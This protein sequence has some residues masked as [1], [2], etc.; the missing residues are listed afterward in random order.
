MN[1]DLLNESRSLMPG[2]GRPHW[3][4]EEADRDQIDRTLDEVGQMVRAFKSAEPK[5]RTMLE[6]MSGIKGWESFGAAMKHGRVFVPFGTFLGIQFILNRK[7]GDVV[8][9]DRVTFEVSPVHDGGY[10]EWGIQASSTVRNV[11]KGHGSDR[12]V[13]YHDMGHWKDPDVWTDPRKALAPLKGFFRKA[14]MLKP[15][16]E[17][18]LRRSGELT[19]GTK[20]PVFNPYGMGMWVIRVEDYLY[21]ITG[22]KW[23][24]KKPILTIEG[25]KKIQY[26]WVGRK[27]RGA[28]SPPIFTSTVEY[29]KGPDAFDIETAYFDGNHIVASKTHHHVYIEQA[30]DPSV[31]FGWVKQKWS[32]KTGMKNENAPGP[33]AVS[34]NPPSIQDM[35]DAVREQIKAPSWTY[36]TWALPKVQLDEIKYKSPKLDSRLAKKVMALGKKAFEDGRKSIPIHDPALMRLLKK[37]PDLAVPVMDAWSKGFHRANAAAPVPGMGR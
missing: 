21:K 10:R 4:L 17:S 28:I 3:S 18:L 6:R 5:F 7:E 19:E 20:T 22:K 24:W 29:K 15:K 31:L 1:D 13:E 8:R 35:V 12:E 14:E 11:P 23:T 26:K 32:K 30:I 36:P 9:M 16:G 2:R 27:K 25:G 34:D 37:H 33:F